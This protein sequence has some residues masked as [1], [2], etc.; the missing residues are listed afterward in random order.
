MKTNSIIVILSIVLFTSFFVVNEN[1][2]APEAEVSI[3]GI[4]EQEKIEI[5]E[6]IDEFNAVV[7]AYSAWETCQIDICNM[8]NTER[9]YINA[10]ACPRAFSFGTEVLIGKKH[11]ICSDRTALKFD[12]RFDIFMGYGETAYY[13]AISFGKKIE[14]VKIL[15][16]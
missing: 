15:K 13:K 12:G 16:K 10:I 9:A 3:I 8:A 6:I 5:Y 1:V 4:Q 11:Y 14:Q 2:V 7:T